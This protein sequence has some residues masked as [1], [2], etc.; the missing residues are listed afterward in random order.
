MAAELA[1]CAMA[2]VRLKKAREYLDDAVQALESCQEEKLIE[3]ARLGPMLVDV[4]DLARDVD[5]LIAELR[6]R[7]ERGVE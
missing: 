5:E 3:P 7:L 2:I 4:G 6:A 1:F